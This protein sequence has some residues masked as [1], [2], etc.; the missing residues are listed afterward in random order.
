M[1]LRLRVRGAADGLNDGHP[2]GGPG[3]P[4]GG[5]RPKSPENDL[6]STTIAAIHADRVRACMWGMRRPTASAK[7]RPI[8]T[9]CMFGS[10]RRR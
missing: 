8:D 5:R 2:E 9:L 4:G 10:A 7:L 3:W 1:D 6:Q